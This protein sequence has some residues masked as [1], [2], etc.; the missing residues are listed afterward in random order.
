MDGLTDKSHFELNVYAV[1]VFQSIP[2]LG[3]YPAYRG[4]LLLAGSPLCGARL[5]VV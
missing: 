4:V 3:R 5:G 2:P 1:D